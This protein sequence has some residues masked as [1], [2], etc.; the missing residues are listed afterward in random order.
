MPIPAQL[1]TTHRDGQGPN[2]LYHVEGE[3]VPVLRLQ[4]GGS[5]PAY[6][7]HH[8]LLWK[9]PTIDIQLKPMKGAFK[10]FIAGMPIFLTHA[11]GQGQIAFSRDGTGQIV[12]MH[13]QPGQSIEVREH[14]FLAATDNVAYTFTR[15]KGIA[16]ML[17][18]STGFFIDRFT[19]EQYE[20]IVFLHG[21]GNV[22]EVILGPNEVI[23]VEPGGWLYKDAS[24][25]MEIKVMGLRSGIF[26]GSGQLV[27]NR[28]HGPG[29]LGIQ[30]MYMHLGDSA[31]GGGSAAG[32]AI[33]AVGVAARTLGG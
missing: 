7:E 27:F 3:L 20:G 26:A 23:D 1:P 28:F 19:A 21:Y 13:L 5:V 17:F 33:G 16:N 14:Q 4:L 25:R 6:F 18:G 9:E 30:S 29:R 12:P 8:V 24:V 31:T 11:V 22:F 32:T 15:V 2:L 10:R